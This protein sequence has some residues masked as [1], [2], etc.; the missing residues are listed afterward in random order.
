VKASQRKFGKG[1]LAALFAGAKS[2]VVSRGAKAAALNLKAAPPG[3]AAFA[4]AVLGPTGN[5]RAP[6]ARLGKGAWL[7]GFGEGSW[8]EA[9]G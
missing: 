9:L 4:A 6:T 8:G 7:V 5:L 1:E 3:S 2:V